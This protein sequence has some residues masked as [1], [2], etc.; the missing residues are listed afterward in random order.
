MIEQPLPLSAQA[1]IGLTL[2]ILCAR[3]IY[4]FYRSGHIHLR[5]VSLDFYRDERPVGY[6]IVFSISVILEAI[7]LA[8]TIGATMEWATGR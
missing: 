1:L 3:E 8:A 6:W 2:T 4:R 7:I 5:K